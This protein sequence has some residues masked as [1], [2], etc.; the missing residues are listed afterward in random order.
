MYYDPSG[1]SLI[2]LLG[3]LFAT[4]TA[5]TEFAITTVLFAGSIFWV[6]E[7]VKRNWQKV[8]DFLM[9]D[10][11]LWEEAGNSY[12]IPVPSSYENEFTSISMSSSGQ[13]YMFFSNY[14][15]DHGDEDLS[16]LW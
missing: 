9:K 7:M 15:N 16:L 5:I 6:V 13:I 11:S 8:E 10:I 12:D 4:A 14:G 2:A 1:H 3:T